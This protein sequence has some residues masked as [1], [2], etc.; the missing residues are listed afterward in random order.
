MK[1]GMTSV[2]FRNKSIEEITDIATKAGLE[3]IEWG[4][5]IHCPPSNK[6][7]IKE[8]AEKTKMGYCYPT[9]RAAFDAAVNALKE[10]I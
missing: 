8:A 6:E 5:D 2:T 10:L 4:G 3:V 9:S 1:C 7:L